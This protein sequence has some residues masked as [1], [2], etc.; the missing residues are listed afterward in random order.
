MN[1]ILKCFSSVEITWL[2]LF[3][4]QFLKLVP[5]LVTLSLQKRR[6]FGSIDDSP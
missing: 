6:V 5:G 2:V 3:W 1:L 4:E